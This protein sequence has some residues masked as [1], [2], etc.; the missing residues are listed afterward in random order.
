MIVTVAAADVRR[1]HSL[2]CISSP[3]ASF[4][5]TSNT[6]ANTR[7]LLHHHHRCYILLRCVCTRMQV[8]SHCY[9]RSACTMCAISGDKYR[10]LQS[11]SALSL[12]RSQSHSHSD[13]GMQSQ[14]L[15]SDAHARDFFS[16]FLHPHTHMSLCVYTHVVCVRVCV[17][18]VTS[19]SG[20][21]CVY[22]M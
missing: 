6:T 9:Y 14:S 18:C 1:L 20:I 15:S 19:E 4:I 3:L 5:Q 17:A 13:R 22:G 2:K 21:Q 10:S 8:R 7:A 16:H 12:S 11:G